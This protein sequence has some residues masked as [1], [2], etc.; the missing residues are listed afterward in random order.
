MRGPLNEGSWE[1]W[2][3]CH[4]EDVCRIISGLMAGGGGQHLP[5]TQEEEEGYEQSHHWDAVTQ[6]VYNHSYLVVHLAFF[7]QGEKKHRMSLWG[8]L[9]FSRQETLKGWKPLLFLKFSE[10]SP[11]VVLNRGWY[12]NNRNVNSDLKPWFLAIIKV[13]LMIVTLFIQSNKWKPNKQLCI[14]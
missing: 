3:F 7:L 6:E 10:W 11:A 1:Y 9:V 2:R 12:P 8:I 4:I 13:T 5:Q 14:F